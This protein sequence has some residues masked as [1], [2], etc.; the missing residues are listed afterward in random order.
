M[1]DTGQ[2]QFEIS[3]IDTTSEFLDPGDEK[4]LAP[5]SQLA[6]SIRAYKMRMVRLMAYDHQPHH[7]HLCSV[8]RRREKLRHIML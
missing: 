2:S 6:F 5:C 4:I 7:P 1:N 3:T 8:R